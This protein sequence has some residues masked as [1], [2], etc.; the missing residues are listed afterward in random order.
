MIVLMLLY[1][2]FVSKLSGTKM[3]KEKWNLQVHQGPSEFWTAAEYEEQKHK[4]RVDTPRPFE[5][6]KLFYPSS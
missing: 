1:A 2:L 6:S 5:E 3:S 4:I